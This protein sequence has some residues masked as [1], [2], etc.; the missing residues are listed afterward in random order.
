MLRVLLTIGI[1]G[2]VLGGLFAWYGFKERAVA[3]ES[4][5][6]PETMTLNQ[7]IARGPE[8]NANVV[9]TDFTL[10]R[11]HAVERGRRNRWSGAWVPIVP[12]DA[13]P[14]T[15]PKVFVYTTE[16]RSPEEVYQQV[17]GPQLAG[18]VINKIK[19]PKG[20]VEDHFEE[21]YPQVDFDTAIYIEEGRTPS[22]ETTA[23]LMILGG[24][25]AAVIGVGSLVLALIVWQ[26]NKA[27]EARQ[28]KDRKKR[29]SRDDDEDDDDRPRKRR[30]ARDEDN[31][32]APPRKR[33]IADEDDE[34]PR[35][36]RRPID[37]DDDR[38]S[39][40][41]VARDEDEDDRPRR[42][43]PVD[44]DEDDRPRRRPRR[45]D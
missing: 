39:R 8:G 40:R 15:V 7:L 31:D 5:P 43:R 1:G 26:K 35:K 45:D 23:M 24:I 30:A 18:L 29:R 9:V 44:D 4:S 3:S 11:D 14:G 20:S 42:R 6:T 12:K 22:S 33:R 13:A 38:P 21:R 25:A 17:S 36:K 27:A 32:E 34:A 41:R 16:G 28:K 10:I 2:P 19:T 37:E